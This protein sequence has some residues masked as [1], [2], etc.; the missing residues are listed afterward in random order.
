MSLARPSRCIGITVWIWT[1]YF[2]SAVDSLLK[3]SV[4]SIGPGD[5]PTTRMFLG[6]SSTAICLVKAS[7][8]ALAVPA[9]LWSIVPL[10]CR[11]AVI[12]MITPPF[13]IAYCTVNLDNKKVPTVSIIS[14]FLKAL[15]DKFSKGHKKFPAAPLTK[16]SISPCFSVIAFTVYSISFSFLTSQEL[17]QMLLLPV[18]SPKLFTA[19][20][21]FSIFLLMM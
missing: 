13:F 20:L 1:P 6:P 14:T 10:W 18:D 15:G 17:P 9:W 19:L 4:F 12:L 11:L 7:T 16:M 3:P 21:I 8:P 2:P 5:T